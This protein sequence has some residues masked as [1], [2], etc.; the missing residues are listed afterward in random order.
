MRDVRIKRVVCESA[1]VAMDVLT[2]VTETLLSNGS[3]LPR[4]VGN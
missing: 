1:P 3:K 4:D 2:L